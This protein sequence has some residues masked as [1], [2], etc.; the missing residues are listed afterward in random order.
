MVA[1]HRSRRADIVLRA[2][3]LLLCWVSYTAISRLVAMHVP[4]Q[5]AG[6]LAYG[7][8]AVGFMAASAGSALTLLGHHFF[9][10]IEV[11]ARWRG[12]PDLNVFSPSEGSIAMDIPEPAMLVVGRDIDGDWTVR[13]SAGMLLGRF[14][15]AQAAQRFAEAERRGRTSISVAMSAGTPRRIEGRL[16]LVCDRT[17]KGSMARG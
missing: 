7:I 16:S 17:L 14:S 12:R 2:T 9:D 13:E 5:K 4:P 1:W 8:A 10:E 11:S 6:V 15:S 3:G